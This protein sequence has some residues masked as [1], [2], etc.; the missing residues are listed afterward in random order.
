MLE[1]GLRRSSK[2]GQTLVR[3]ENE[4]RPTA[5]GRVVP[6]VAMVP[7]DVVRGGGPRSAAG[8][9]P[10]RAARGGTRTEPRPR[11]RPRPGPGRQ[12]DVF[13]ARGS[14]LGGA[15]RG[16]RARRFYGACFPALLGARDWMLAGQWELR[17]S[18]WNS[19]PPCKFSLWG[20]ERRLGGPV[21]SPSC[22]QAGVL[23][24]RALVP[25]KRV[26][27]LRA[28]LPAPRCSPPGGVGMGKTDAPLP[29]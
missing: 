18:L 10:G 6:A 13:F 5:A 25:C 21:S 9:V 29:L 22:M 15:G 16:T 12:T 8:C 1:L 26:G 14:H 17:G 19:G 28:A 7:G 24:S 27:A 11:P 2:S 3:G 20:L 23:S 4:T